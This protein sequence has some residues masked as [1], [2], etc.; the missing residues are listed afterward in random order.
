MSDGQA[1]DATA[2]STISESRRGVWALLG[3]FA[4]LAFVLHTILYRGYGFFRDE[5]YFI[6]CSKH[7]AW[8]YVDQPPG[9]A[10]LAWL[11]RHL[12]VDNLFA[13]RFF[14]IV[15]VSL[16]IILV[17]LAARAMGGS[18]FAIALACL[19]SRCRNISA[20]GSTPTC[21]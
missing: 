13:V 7:L 12:F 4:I 19:L 18:R 14:P 16:L 6:A 8:G 5:L 10:V 17:G 3:G 21:S 1:A 20:R 15:F 9:V 11:G 2:Q